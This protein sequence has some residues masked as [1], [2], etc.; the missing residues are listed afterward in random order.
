[1]AENQY[2]T[3]DP[4]TTAEPI[5][6]RYPF[7][8][9]GAPGTPRGVETTE[10]SITITWTKPRSDG[11]S[12]ITGYVIEKRLINEQEKWIKATQAIIS[13]TT[14]K[15]AGLI[16]NRDYE[17]RVAAVNAAGQGPWSA[18]SDAIRA[19]APPSKYN[20]YK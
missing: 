5:K 9:P 12:P 6:A 20:F 2:G 17:F 4:A 14:Y 11:G 16:E 15:C 1:M 19:S 8:V 13:D 3:S 18:G 10:D 7:D